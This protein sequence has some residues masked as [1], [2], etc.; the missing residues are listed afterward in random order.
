[1][2][3][4]L[5]LLLF[6]LFL[7]LYYNSSISNLKRLD[8]D[9]SLYY[10]EYNREYNNFLFNLAFRVIR[11]GSCSA[12]I[13]KNK[14]NEFLTCRNYDMPHKDSNDN[15]TGLNIVLKIKGRAKYDSIN[16]IDACW[17]KV[18]KQPF[19]KGSLDNPKIN[20]LPL[21]LLPYLA[22]DGIN[23]KGFSVSILAL[24]LKEGEKPVSQNE[25]GKKKIVIN[26]LV[27]LMIDNCANVDEAIK[28]ANSYNLVAMLGYDYH[29]F[30]SDANGQSRVLEWRYNTL[31]AIDTD[32]VTNFY[33]STDD[34]E[35]CYYGKDL[36]E[37]FK[38]RKNIND[39][40]Y[41]Y[42]HGYNRFNKAA[43]ELEKHMLKNKS[44]KMSDDDAV[45]I[46]NKISQDYDGMLTSY[47]QYSVIYNNTTHNATFYAL[48]DYKNKY[49][50]S[51]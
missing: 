31:K 16:G 42:G 40:H 12:F 20:K 32:L 6:I 3:L 8:K 26:Q 28:L 15:I 21:C 46:L 17:L 39:Y 48:K 30:I 50:F 7:Y 35:D 47:T 45:D 18:L 51:I 36:K 44:T 24:D 27:R 1:M 41:G 34:A 25:K 22:M 19:F 5:I 9:G 10:G 38:K 23:E 37:K 13:T 11:G 33:V 4:L 14:H 49:T 2:I 29:L 43:K